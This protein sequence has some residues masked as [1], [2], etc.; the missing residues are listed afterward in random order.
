MKNKLIR[1]FYKII[2]P[3]RK[4]YWFI[5]R[6]KIR[7][8][9]CV[10]EY[11]DSILLVRI[12]YAHKGWTLPGGGVKRRET[13]EEAARREAKEETGI[14]LPVVKKN[15]RIYHITRTQDYRHRSFLFKG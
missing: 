12:S 15:L 7:G 2:N 3:F 8:V 4:L 5:F 11:N 10:I 9:K 14:I 6:P 13:F 1:L